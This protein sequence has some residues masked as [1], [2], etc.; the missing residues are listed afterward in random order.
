MPAGMKGLQRSRVNV[1]TRFR[2]TGEGSQ[3]AYCCVQ[4]LQ[5]PNWAVAPAPSLLLPLGFGEVFPASQILKDQ[6]SQVRTQSDEDGIEILQYL[7]F[8]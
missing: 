8:M 4:L 5:T 6:N 3:D 7:A 2:K 1:F